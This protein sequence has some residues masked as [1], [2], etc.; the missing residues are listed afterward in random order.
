MYLDGKYA[1]CLIH[2][3]D[4]QWSSRVSINPI[5]KPAAK[6]GYSYMKLT[7]YFIKCYAVFC[8]ALFST[9]CRSCEHMLQTLVKEGL[10]LS[11]GCLLILR[12]SFAPVW[13]HFVCN[14]VFLFELATTNIESLLSKSAWI[15]RPVITVE[16]LAKMFVR[17]TLLEH[18]HKLKVIVI[19]FWLFRTRLP[20][21]YYRTF[22]G[23]TIERNNNDYKIL[24]EV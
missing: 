15:I 13:K 23:N 19:S 4:G 5:E 12:S 9:L 24:K 1:L 2:S 10:H 20:M 8:S 22:I 16:K 6:A 21:L 11:I 14:A 18:L 7:E 3:Y 17:L